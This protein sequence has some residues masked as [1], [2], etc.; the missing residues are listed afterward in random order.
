MS[1]DWFT[2]LSVTEA[3]SLAERT[4]RPLLVD[5]WSPTC[6]GCAK[7]AVTTLRDPGV[8]AVLAEEFVVVKYK[9]TEP[10]EWFR[11]LNGHVAHVWHPHLVVMDHRRVEGRRFIGYQTPAQ[12]LAHLRLGTGMLH[13]FTR[14]WDAA[15][16]QF[17]QALESALPDSLTAE[18]L[19]WLGVAGYRVAGNL[20]GLRP[21]WQRILTEFPDTDWAVRADCL[22]VRI[23]PEGFD[24]G[25]PATVRILDAQASVAP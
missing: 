9:T 3:I 11:T 19:Y 8:C 16:R 25:D 24:P 12:F 17:E 21:H 2:N 1:Q 18:V 13:L 5:F 7:L 10:D 23:P 22:D 20:D 4:R 14:S 6:L 15:Y